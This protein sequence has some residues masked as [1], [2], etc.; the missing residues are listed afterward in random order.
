MPRSQA[1]KISLMLF[2]IAIGLA[3]ALFNALHIEGKPPVISLFVIVCGIALVVLLIIF[4]VFQ[5][6]PECSN[7]EYI[8]TRN[9]LSKEEIASKTGY[10]TITR[11]EHNSKDEEKRHWQEQVRVKTIEYLHTYQ[12][13]NCSHTWTEKS[14][15]QF[16]DFDD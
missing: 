6:S 5:F 10:R 9:E 16:Q 14:T 7:C 1:N 11:H 3:I 12:C 8:F 4:A 2:A 13:T 15:K